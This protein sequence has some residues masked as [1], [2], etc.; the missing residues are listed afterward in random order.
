MV[1]RGLVFEALIAW[2]EHRDGRRY[3][4]RVDAPDEQGL[5]HATPERWRAVRSGD[6]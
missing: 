3:L 5:L 2:R 1:L 4:W 6:A